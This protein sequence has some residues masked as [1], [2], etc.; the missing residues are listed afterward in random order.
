MKKLILFLFVLI[1][2]FAFTSCGSSGSDSLEEK[3][4][5]AAQEYID[6]EDS[7]TALKVI[8]EG[9]SKIPDSKMLLELKENFEKDLIAEETEVVE[10]FSPTEE[11]IIND[12]T[13]LRMI[14]RKWFELYEFEYDEAAGTIDDNY[15]FKAPVKDATVK[16]KADL[17]SLFL[18]Y[19]NDN[20]YKT[21]SERSFVSFKDENGKLYC[22][23]PEAFGYASTADKNIKVKK[24][25]DTDYQLT[26][27]EEVTD[28]GDVYS[29]NVSLAYTLNSD[30][31][32]RFG[33]ET[34]TLNEDKSESMN[35]DSNYSADVTPND[36]QIV[37]EI[38]GDTLNG[39]DNLINDI[40]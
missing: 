24:L 25:T 22:V 1:I 27:T 4:V 31:V 38:V 16:T 10:S 3:Y 26:Y 36:H 35:Y 12:F 9:L 33:T 21:Y 34:R 30:G 15:M 28:E 23:M 7:E 39:I 8:E 37:E 13:A 17:D 11:S 20:L 32:W 29:Y 18:K 5:N 6:K 14:Y 2:I 40:L 19:C